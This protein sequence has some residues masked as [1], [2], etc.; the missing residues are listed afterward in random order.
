MSIIDPLTGRDLARTFSPEGWQEGLDRLRAAME[1]IPNGT[2]VTGTRDDIDGHRHEITGY[3][4]ST[5]LYMARYVPPGP[6]TSAGT[7]APGLER[8]LYP[9]EFETK[10]AETKEN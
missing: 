2:M 5:G 9:H 3:D 6:L 1:R 10:P 8:E 7:R 4:S